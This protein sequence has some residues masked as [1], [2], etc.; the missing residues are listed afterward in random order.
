MVEGD[1]ELERLRPVYAAAG[2]LV[3]LVA[4]VAALAWYLRAETEP[5]RVVIVA[6]G[7]SEGCRENIARRAAFL[8]RQRGFDSYAHSGSLEA[9]LAEHDAL[10][11]VELEL[12]HEERRPLVEGTYSLEVDVRATTRTAREP[13]REPTALTFL[14][15]APTADRA[16]LDAGLA[17]IDALISQ[18]EVEILKSAAIARYIEDGA[19]P[20][21]LDRFQIIDEARS[22]VSDYEQGRARF[23][24]LC[25]EVAAELTADGT[26]CLTTSCGNEYLVDVLNADTALL[27]VETADPVFV[28]GSASDVKR[29]EVPERYVVASID[30][31]RREV[32]TTGNLFSSAT[33]S[34]D[35]RWLAYVEIAS[36]GT[37]VLAR[38]SMETGERE[39]VHTVGAP[40]RLFFPDIS[41]NGRWIA[42]VHRPFAGAD[43]TIYVADVEGGETW[44][45]AEFAVQTHWVE[46]ALDG[47]RE[48]LLAVTIPAERNQLPIDADS[49]IDESE[50]D[51]DLEDE[52]GIDV[53]REPDEELPPLTHIA[54]V[55]PGTDR[56]DVVARIGGVERHIGTVAGTRDDTLLLTAATP[57]IG[58]ELARWNAAE[59]T[60]TY[61]PLD[62]CIG[63][64]SLGP[65]DALY[66]DAPSE[67]GDANIVRLDPDTGALSHLVDHAIRD[68]WARPTGTPS[69]VRVFFE[70]IPERR[71]ARHPVAGVCW[72]DLNGPSSPE[73]NTATDG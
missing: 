48:P 20:H 8:L 7:C 50:I 27:R 35:G 42:F 22:G 49:A 65:D 16:L 59:R 60:A 23:A 34:A 67:R 29:A 21:D 40:A 64:P 36:E 66:G 72:V 9:G 44:E 19:R 46:L 38:M 12:D 56:G 55:R 33:L 37:A 24:E 39:V 18:I 68:R 62:A 58:C 2:L 51:D 14:R 45:P 30:G 57:L 61:S 26:R 41:P 28:L 71:Y 47:A 73:E 43:A 53:V 17:G 5:T 25:D 11:G 4:V 63:Y 31:T 32:L 6:Q 52:P 69:Q 70:R 13:A 15:E 54:L 1:E 3:A 10:H